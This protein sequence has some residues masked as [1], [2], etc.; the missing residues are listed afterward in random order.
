M[1][2]R[3]HIDTPQA[4]ILAGWAIDDYGAPCEIAVAVNGGQAVHILSDRPRTDLLAEGI[5]TGLGGFRIDIAALMTLGE[6]QVTLTFPD[7]TPVPGSPITRNFAGRDDAN[8]TY[9]GAID[10]PQGRTIGGWAVTE[11]GRPCKLTVNINGMEP[12]VVETTRERP[13]LARNDISQGLGGF[14]IEVLDKLREGTNRVSLRFPN[15]EHLPGSPIERIVGD[16]AAYTPEPEAAP[17]PPPPAPPPPP[18]PPPPEVRAPG[19][20]RAST[21]AP[22][23]DKAPKVRDRTPSPASPLPVAPRKK[24]ALPSLAELDELSLD[25]LSL[26]VAAGVITVPPPEVSPL[27]TE[28]IAERTDSDSVNQPEAEPVPQLPAPEPQRRGL[29]S[30]LF[31]RG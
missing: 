2:Y 23:P 1:P 5:A 21:V 30:R 25:D 9:K 16:P 11:D 13:D 15:G 31:G 6:N 26:A 8:L 10:R 19:S 28:P 18:S 29:I 27:P 14:S 7:G 24:P 22:A 17:P 3:G 4:D 20:E 12:F